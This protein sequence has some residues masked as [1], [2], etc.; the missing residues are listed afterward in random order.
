M[1]LPVKTEQDE[2]VIPYLDAAYTFVLNAFRVPS[3]VLAKEPEMRT[4][5]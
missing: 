5:E 2:W 4:K 1:I 3:V